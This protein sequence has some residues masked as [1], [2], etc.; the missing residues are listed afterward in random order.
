MYILPFINP[1][2]DYTVAAAR[3]LA[4]MAGMTHAAFT[5]QHERVDDIPLLVGVLEQLGVAAVLERH[6][7]SHHLHQGLGNGTLAATWIAFILSEANH[8]KV[9]VQD[10]ALR[11]QQTLATLL[12]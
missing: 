4:N 8:C 12:Q 3:R 11:H 6:L 5:L 1:V 2:L 9:S 10:W 7:G